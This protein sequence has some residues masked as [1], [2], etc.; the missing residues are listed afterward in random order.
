MPLRCTVLGT[1]DF[2][3]GSSLQR[4]AQVGHQSTGVCVWSLELLP[5]GLTSSSREKLSNVNYKLLWKVFKE[6]SDSDSDS[7]M[8]T[9]QWIPLVQSANVNDVSL[10]FS[11]HQ[12]S[13]SPEWGALWGPVRHRS[14]P[15]PLS[16]HLGWA[17]LWTPRR[18]RACLAQKPKP[19]VIPMETTLSNPVIHS[20]LMFQESMLWIT[21]QVPEIYVCVGATGKGVIKQQNRTKNLFWVFSPPRFVSSC[22]LHINI[23][24]RWLNW[25]HKG[26]R[27][28]THDGAFILYSISHQNIQEL[29]RNARRKVEN[30][31]WTHTHRVILS[32]NGALW[33]WVEMDNLNMELVK[34]M[35][36]KSHSWV[37]ERDKYTGNLHLLLSYLIISLHY[38]T[39]PTKCVNVY[40]L[41]WSCVAEVKQDLRSNTRGQP[42]PVFTAHVQVFLFQILCYCCLRTT[43]GSERQVGS[44]THIFIGSVAT[45]I[46]TASICIC[47]CI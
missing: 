33:V 10:R 38:L 18:V 28:P 20:P 42:S 37:K 30:R 25:P 15:A 1:G 23:N 31:L 39:I 47:I 41:A 26:A 19:P 24:K 43:D 32:K 17:K 2:N 8:Y 9:L 40:D 45:Q 5:S 16:A 46:V 14:R 4:Q 11:L 21:R 3:C 44:L 29:R 35:S 27:S 34:S 6:H 13:L 12:D 36:E 7:E 22:L